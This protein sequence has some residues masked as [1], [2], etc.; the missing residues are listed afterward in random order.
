VLAVMLPF[1]PALKADLVWTTIMI[2]GAFAALVP[3]AAAIA[4][5][6]KTK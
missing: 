5:I 3:G 2:M 6:A 1:L 4:S